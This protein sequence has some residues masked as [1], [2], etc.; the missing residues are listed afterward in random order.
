MGGP[1]DTNHSVRAAFLA[2]LYTGPVGHLAAGVVD[3]A[4]LALRLARERWGG[5]RS[6]ARRRVSSR[7]DSA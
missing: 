4:A 2:W 5:G 7:R 1:H 3:W 6:R